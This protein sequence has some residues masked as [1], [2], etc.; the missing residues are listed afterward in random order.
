[1]LKGDCL[2][3]GAGVSVN[4]TGCFVSSRAANETFSTLK[5]AQIILNI[6]ISKPY[7][8]ISLFILVS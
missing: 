7:E 6:Q 1:M 2:E 4:S 5:T 8:S 3:K